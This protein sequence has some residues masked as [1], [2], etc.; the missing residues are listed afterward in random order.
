MILKEAFYVVGYIQGLTLLNL[1]FESIYSSTSTNDTENEEEIGNELAVFAIK[2]IEAPPSP[3]RENT[4][5]EQVS[6]DTKLWYKFMITVI[7]SLLCTLVP[8]F[9]LP[10]YWPILLAYFLFIFVVTMREPLWIML[11]K[12]YTPMNHQ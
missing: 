12:R 6:G 5:V 10:V 4:I 11:T 9:N 1:F 8:F 2:D 3:I 7:I